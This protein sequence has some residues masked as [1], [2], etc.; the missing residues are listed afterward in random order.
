MSNAIFP[1]MA[2]VSWGVGRSPS[3]NTNVHRSAS[4]RE[5]RGALAAYPLWTFSLAFEVLR[6]DLAFTELQTLGG[7]FLARRGSFDSFLYSDPDDN[8]VT[9]QLFGLGDGVTTQFQLVRAWGSFVEPTMAIN[10]A[11]QIYIA[12]VLK[13]LTTDYTIDGLGM[14]TFVAAP[15][16][17]ASLTWTGAYYYRVRFTKDMADFTKFMKN[18][19]ELKS[20]EFV[21]STGNKV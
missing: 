14:V 19:W 13:T 18:L 9:A 21:G 4:Q 6:S 17:A 20:L 1:V 10:G 7:F 2:G 3:F 8:A 12:G 5:A 16:A 15:A 11:A